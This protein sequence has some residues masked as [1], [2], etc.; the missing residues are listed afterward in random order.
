MS[1]LDLE[2]SYQAFL[3]Q[4]KSAK[5]LDLGCGQGRVLAFLQSLGYQN[6]EGVDVR[7]DYIAHVKS[8]YNIEVHQV[9][10]IFKF[11]ENCKGNYDFIIAKDVIYY[12]PKEQLGHLMD[13]LNAALS[14]E[15]SIIVEVFNGSTFTGPFVK[16]KD[17]GILSILTEHSLFSL[18]SSS[19]F[20]EIQIFG[21]RQKIRSLK[22]AIFVFFQWCWRKVLLGIYFLERGLD[23]ENPKILEKQIIAVAKKEIS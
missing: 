10:D 11:L 23:S 5:I 17:T 4:S 3:P 19:H 18:L 20:K 8:T 22:S 14:P 21:K 13:L 16:Y 7:A 1:F 12:L 2:Y 9:E 6:L 15:G